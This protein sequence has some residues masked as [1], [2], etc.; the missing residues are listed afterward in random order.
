MEI[1]PD[2]KIVGSC[3]FI[4]AM[5]DVIFITDDIACKMIARKI[6]GLNV[7]SVCKDGNDIY[8][9]YKIIRGN[10]DKINFYM[11]NIDYSD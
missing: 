4:N 7:E 10:A 3:A 9:G 11:Q 6:F 5:K 2:T 8:K 1:T